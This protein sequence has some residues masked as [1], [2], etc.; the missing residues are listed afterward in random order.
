MSNKCVLCFLYHFNSSFSKYFT[1]ITKNGLQGPWEERVIIV[2]VA[3]VLEGSAD[4]K[5]NDGKSRFVSG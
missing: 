4:S 1:A 5:C 2:V 3:G